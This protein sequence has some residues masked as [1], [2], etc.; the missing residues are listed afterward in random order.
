MFIAAV[1]ILAA[2]EVTPND[3]T[4]DSRENAIHLFEGTFK[5][6]DVVKDSEQWFSFSVTSG[7]TYYIHVI[8]G[9]LEYMNIRVF[10]RTGSP[11]GGKVDLWWD[12]VDWYFSR[13]LPGSGTYYIWVQ[14]GM[15]PGWP[16]Y[17]SDSGTY[18]IAFNKTAIPP[19]R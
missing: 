7:G 2:C 3:G 16:Y 8:F 12:D 6:G 14:P 5:D 9:T 11:V 13:E 10:N 17:S 4:G 18:R 1:L 15:R 19:T